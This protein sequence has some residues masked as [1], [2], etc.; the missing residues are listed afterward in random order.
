VIDIATMRY[1]QAMKTIGKCGCREEQAVKLGRTLGTRKALQRE[2]DRCS[3][4]DR[5][6]RGSRVGRKLICSWYMAYQSGGCP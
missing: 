4:V 6:A 1:R 2:G 3:T 5:V